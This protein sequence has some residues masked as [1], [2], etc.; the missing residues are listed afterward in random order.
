[1][2]RTGLVVILGGAAIVA[3]AALASGPR[4]AHPS[5]TPTRADAEVRE[6][7][8][9]FYERR[10]AED[11]FSAADRA[12]LASLYLQR[13]RETGSPQDFDRAESFAARSIAMRSA[14]NAETY[15]LL[16][17][18]RLARHDFLG[19]RKSA[20]A[21]FDADS[22][23]PSARAQLGEVELELGNYRRAAQLFA[24]VARDV[25][26]PTIA[27]RVARWYEI[28]GRS[29]RA[30]TLLRHGARS[31]T[32][33]MDVPREQVAWFHYRL[34]ELEM[35]AGRFEV[36]DSV[37]RH[38]L[39]VFPDDYRALGALSRL[40]A[41]RGQW[42]AAVEYGAKA[43]AI[44][45]D[46]STL[47]TMSDAYSALGD[48][49]QARSFADAMATS[50]LSEPGSIHRAWGLFLL[51]HDRDVQRVLAGAQ[52]D[53]AIRTDVYAYD[54]VAW[55]LYKSGRVVEAANAARA[56]LAQGTEDPQLFYH[57]GMIAIAAGDSAEAR[58]LLTRA[59]ALN[60]TFSP[61]QARVARA[62]LATLGSPE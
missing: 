12:R 2:K 46:P 30:R 53:L 22:A 28:T 16:T 60:P 9:A 3:V 4:E 27:A 39:A 24:S 7:D 40:S 15:G 43:I 45:L 25:G 41:M 5:P 6:L 61:T 48:S 55:A 31:L 58:A 62:A 32:Q 23:N 54:L 35:R 37:L 13:A 1:M 19:A 57:A 18:A 50:A 34:G 21:L 44:Q 47:G 8:I 36:A 29:D 10:V 59:V 49:V 26:K 17:T 51:D 20:R 52:A 14:H 33:G 42:N 11:S 38:A 56:A